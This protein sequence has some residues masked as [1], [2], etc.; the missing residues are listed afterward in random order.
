M[1]GFSG[2]TSLI[3]LVVLSLALFVSCSDD[4]KDSG[5]SSPATIPGAPEMTFA[6]H[7]GGS[8]G[9]DF[10]IIFPLMAGATEYRLYESA[11][12]V[13]YTGKDTSTAVS[14]AT[15]EYGF[16]QVMS[17][18]DMYYYVKAYNSKGE[19]EAGPVV[20]AEPGDFS[21]TGTFITYP[22]SG[23]QIGSL[24]PT[25]T[26]SGVAGATMYAIGVYSLSSELWDALL[27]NGTSCTYGEISANVAYFKSAETLSYG[28][29]GVGVEA[30]NANNWGFLKD[31][32]QFEI[33]A[34]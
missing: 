3:G 34:K 20:F 4:D 10:T 25:F 15:Y 9:T 12:G 8:V 33:I 5:T 18:S 17:F 16:F 27:T 19:G 11:D 6:I 26:L 7:T 29:Y 21:S 23:Q 30:I 2:K 24:T 13:T 28:T 22:A 1:I 32:N 31:D 14:Y